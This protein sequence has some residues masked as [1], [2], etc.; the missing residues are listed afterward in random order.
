MTAVEAETDSVL[1]D[2]GTED[3][4]KIVLIT[5][6]AAVLAIVRAVQKQLTASVDSNK[7]Y[8]NILEIRCK[9]DE[10]EQYSLTENICISEIVSCSLRII[11]QRRCVNSLQPQAQ[12]LRK[13]ISPKC[14]FWVEQEA[15]KAVTHNS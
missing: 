2:F 14:T 6:K 11:L 4:N 5:I 10:L 8:K 7:R 15:G 3:L 9:E 12:V 1:A 13:T